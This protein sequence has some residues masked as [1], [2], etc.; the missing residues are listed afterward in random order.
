MPEEGAVD[1]K[2]V[3][4]GTLAEQGIRL[5]IL[6][7]AGI[8]VA[9]DGPLR[10]P[11]GV[12]QLQ[13]CVV[14]ALGTAVEPGLLVEDRRLQQ[15]VA[16]EV[17]LVGE[18]HV[19]HLAVAI[20]HGGIL[21]AVGL[22]IL[23]TAALLV[24]IHFPGGEGAVEVAAPDL[25]PGKA[26]SLRLHVGG[27]AIYPGGEGIAPQLHRHGVEHQGGGHYALVAHLLA[28]A[29]LLG[30][31]EAHRILDQVAEEHLGAGVGE[32]V[33]DVGVDERRQAA[34]AVGRAE[35]VD[36]TVVVIAGVEV[37]LVADHIDPAEQETGPAGLSGDLAKIGVGGIGG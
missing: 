29:Q 10:A 27:A 17:E 12:S 23:L 4:I 6:A 15:L 21:G 32:G 9:D 25:V 18:R 11:L 16:A 8:E 7:L 36:T 37:G 30:E 19:V 26:H 28:Q 35:V 22:V 20:Q 34:L 33:A 2:L 24:Q 1:G 5:V 13:P 3:C 14:E 31:V